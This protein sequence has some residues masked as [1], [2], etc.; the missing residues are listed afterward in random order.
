[1]PCDLILVRLRAVRDRLPADLAPALERNPWV[2]EVQAEGEKARFQTWNGIQGV[3]Y[4][5]GEDLVFL[6]SGV[7]PDEGADWARRLSVTLVG[8]EAVM[9]P[10]A[11]PT[12]VE[13]HT[14]GSG[15]VREVAQ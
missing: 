15:L 14:P 3:A 7:L 6:L 1:M 13:D 11:V 9:D 12:E 5:E 8:A 2:T 10:L 4:S